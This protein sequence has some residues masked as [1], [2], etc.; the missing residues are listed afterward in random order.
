MVLYRDEVRVYHTKRSMKL[1]RDFE[2]GGGVSAWIETK[3]FFGYAERFVKS[4]H[5]TICF[6]ATYSMPSNL[7]RT[8]SALFH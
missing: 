6:L 4:V 2:W 8:L 5:F 3:I 7:Q 1:L